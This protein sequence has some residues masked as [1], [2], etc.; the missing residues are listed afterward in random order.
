MLRV[1]SFNVENL[2]ARPRVFRTD[3]WNAGQPALD[4]YHEVSELIA[5]PSYNDEDKTRM[6]DLLVGLDIYSRN[7]HGAIRRNH[8][9]TPQWAWLRKNRGT[10]DRE[11]HDVTQDV[12]ITATGRDDWIAWVELA[13]Q[14]TDETGTRMTAKVIRDT[15][16]DIL[17]VVEAEDR[18]A[19]VRFNSELLEGG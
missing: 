2:F 17:G 10:F 13:T 11:P 15:H 12:E 6:R 9:C 14:P 8:T 16:P 18:P 7:A 3:D 5:K 4:A 19:M 1:A